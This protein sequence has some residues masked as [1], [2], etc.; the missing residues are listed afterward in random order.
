MP[1]TLAKVCRWSKLGS[2][3]SSKDLMS[4]VSCSREIL[5]RLGLRASAPSWKGES[6]PGPGCVSVE[7]HEFDGEEGV[8][9]TSASSERPSGS[10]NKA[11]ELEGSIVLTAPHGMGVASPTAQVQT[12]G[13][14]ARGRAHRPSRNVCQR[15]WPTG[16]HFRDVTDGRISYCIA[17]HAGDAAVRT[18]HCAVSSSYPQLA[19]AVAAPP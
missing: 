4:T 12:R 19:P 13:T 8:R 17:N 6:T 7:D 14:R 18:L 10:A 5:H 1:R 9:P 16:A 11:Q 2:G 15:G 3:S